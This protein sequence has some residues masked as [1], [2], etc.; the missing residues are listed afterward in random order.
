[1]DLAKTSG[2]DSAGSGWS[3][4]APA[5]TI[6]EPSPTELVLHG[7]VRR[8][9]A[10]RRGIVAE[11]TREEE[12]VLGRVFAADFFNEIGRI[13]NQRSMSQGDTQLKPRT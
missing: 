2:E 4:E 8:V 11:D 5:S 12:N 1:M 9:A 13:D 7:T 3:V 10:S 6:S